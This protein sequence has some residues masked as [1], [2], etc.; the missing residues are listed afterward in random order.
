MLKAVSVYLAAIFFGGAA[1]AQCSNPTGAAGQMKYNSAAYPNAMSYCNGANW[2]CMS[3]VPAGSGGYVQ[4][5]NAGSFGGD[6]AL[7]WDNAN[8]RLGI[9]TTAPGLP[10]E[11]HSSNR[12]IRLHNTLSPSGH[13][14]VLGPDTVNNAMTVYYEPGG[15]GVYINEGATSWTGIS[16]RR[17]KTNIQP[18]GNGHGLDAIMRLNPVTFTWRDSRANSGIHIGLLAQ[19]VREVL[20]EVVSQGGT[21]D[22]ALANGN[23]EIINDTLGIS[24]AD[25][26][27]PLIKA[28]QELKAANDNLKAE[29]ET[30]A[31]TPSH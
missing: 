9:G 22:I 2:V 8:K 21:T 31:K 15:G 24:Y 16:D 12:Q 30:C 28:V 20:P 4:F 11:I 17:L 3:A 19:E 14:W 10:L 27:I 5:N 23:Q 29:F 7:F 18:F 1:F 13:N 25:L 26:V 6:S